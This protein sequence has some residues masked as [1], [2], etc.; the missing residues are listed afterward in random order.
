M[1]DAFQ[2][3]LPGLLLGHWEYVVLLVAATVVLSSVAFRF[4]EKADARATPVAKERNVMATLTMTLFFFAIYYVGW[5]RLGR[6]PVSPAAETAAKIAGCLLVLGGAAINVAARRTIGRF[7]SDQI[8]IQPHHHVVRAWPYTWARHPM[9]GSLV[10]FGVGMGLLAVNPLVIGATL[11]IFLP[12]MAHRAVR[13]ERNLEAACGDDYRQ[14]QR[15]VPMMLPRLPEYVSRAARA[16]LAAIQVWGLVTR[17]LDLFALSAVLTLGLS[18]VMQR[19]DFRKA[20]KM[21]PFVILLCVSLAAINERLFVLLLIPTFASLMSLSGHCPGTLL[22][23]LFGKERADG[24][25]V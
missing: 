2:G 6:V 22:L 10:F 25:S 17:D 18:F 12:A 7:W 3:D 8:E 11:L 16:G 4:L 23:K 5:F 19:D 1:I 24:K 15:S 13:E 20:Y 21:K 14:L 9:Y